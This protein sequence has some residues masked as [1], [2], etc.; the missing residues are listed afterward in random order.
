[1]ILSLTNVPNYIR[2]FYFGTLL[3]IIWMKIAYSADGST[4]LVDTFAIYFNT[5]AVSFF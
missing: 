1:M 3:L 5:H 2:N 4:Y